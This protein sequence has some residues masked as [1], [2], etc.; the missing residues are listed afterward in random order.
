HRD[1]EVYKRPSEGN[2][3]FER[4]LS[5]IA[6]KVRAPEAE[7]QSR[8]LYAGQSRGDGV[9]SFMC[10]ERRKKQQ[11]SRNS[12]GRS[13]ADDGYKQQ[14]RD[15]QNGSPSK[16]KTE[17]LHLKV[18]DGGSPYHSSVRCDLDFRGLQL[19]THNST[20]IYKALRIPLARRGSLQG[21][22]LSS[23]GL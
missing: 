11:R 10:R 2:Q 21:K 6:A 20:N 15:G 1:H 22:Y 9:A 3:Y 18:Q 13:E 16:F 7:S 19:P 5:A 4:A 12:V 8:E 23:N 17:F 14:C